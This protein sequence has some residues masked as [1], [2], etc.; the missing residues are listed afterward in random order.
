MPKK[1][2]KKN[3]I[4]KYKKKNLKKR[5]DRVKV[6]INQTNKNNFRQQ[7]ITRIS[8][9]QEQKVEIVKIKKQ[10]TEKRIY[11]IN[12][13]FIKAVDNFMSWR[14]IFNIHRTC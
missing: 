3:K 13:N 10:A 4:K 11:K 1:K 14:H 8:K 2:I 6:K 7:N 12:I 5:V 9:N